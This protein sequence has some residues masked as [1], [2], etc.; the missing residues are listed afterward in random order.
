M[1][2]ADLPLGMRLKEQAG[3]NQ[4]EVDWVRALDLEPEGCFVAELDGR[5]CGTLTTCLF[6]SVAWIA[7]VLVDTGVRGQGIGKALMR[8][9]LEFLDARGVESVRLDATPLGQPLY[10][11]LGFVTQFTLSR[12]AGMLPPAPPVLGVTTASVERWPD[13]MALDR[14]CTGTDRQKLLQRLFEERP[15]EVR[16]IEV[17]G[18]VHGFRSVRVG[19][20]AVQLGPCIANDSAGPVLLADAFHYYQGQR[21]YLDIPLGNPRPLRLAEGQGLRIQRALTR[22]VRGRPVIESI[23]RLWAS[24]GPEKG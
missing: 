5:P 2:G 20:N 24:S 7:L 8:Q 9:G 14:Q 15:A 23:E 21:V 1:T 3:W 4:T 18:R 19:A 17:E 10:E 12:Y 16:L 13:L 6:G 22:M 11:R